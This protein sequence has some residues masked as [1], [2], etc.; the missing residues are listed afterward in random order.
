MAPIAPSKYFRSETI[1][2]SQ[3]SRAFR[4][5]TNAPFT[6]V[7]SPL[8]FDFTNRFWYVGSMD[9]VTP[10]MF[11]MVAVGAI[12]NVFELRIPTVFT[13]SRNPFQSSPSR[14]LAAESTFTSLLR[15]SRRIAIESTGITPL[16]HSE[17]WKLAYAPRSRASSHE[18]S[19]AQKLSNSMLSSANRTASAEANGIR[20]VYSA[21]W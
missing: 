3:S 11:E 20:S 2:S 19:M 1:T 5:R 12:A 7:K 10:Q 14:A 13:R 4:S 18:A 16:L 9:C 6:T 8:M 17:P 15:F 21:S